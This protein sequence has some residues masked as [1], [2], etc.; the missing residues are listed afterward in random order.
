MNEKLKSWVYF[1][2]SHKKNIGYCDITEHYGYHVIHVAEHCD[3]YCEYCDKTEHK[4]INF[5]KINTLR[6][7]LNIQPPKWPQ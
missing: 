7:T 4:I 2:S 1:T 6:R 5:L 3:K